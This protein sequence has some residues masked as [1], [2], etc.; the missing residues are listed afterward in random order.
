MFIGSHSDVFKRLDINKGA[1]LWSRNVGSRIEA[2]FR[3]IDDLVAFGTSER[4]FY[5]LQMEDGEVAWMVNVGRAVKTW[6][7]SAKFLQNADW[8]QW[9]PFDHW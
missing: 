3:L 5:A 6:T 9:T 7:T 2:T 4:Q 1:E 8:L